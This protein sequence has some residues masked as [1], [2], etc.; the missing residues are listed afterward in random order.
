MVPYWA[1]L[2]GPYRALMLPRV[3]GIRSAAKGPIRLGAGFP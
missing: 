2:T 1:L 3:E